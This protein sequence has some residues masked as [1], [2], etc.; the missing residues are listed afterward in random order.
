M[1][2]TIT[3]AT[4][5]K[6]KVFE[7]FLGEEAEARQVM[8]VNTYGG[9]PV[10]AAVAVRNIEILLEEKLPQGAAE[11]G[12]YLM[13]GLTDRL[14]KHAICGEVRGKGLLIGIELGIYPGMA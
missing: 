5:V 11:M 10:A 9:H 3:S 14:M 13:H 8:Q 12:S 4:V 7:S 6:N 2:S 1:G